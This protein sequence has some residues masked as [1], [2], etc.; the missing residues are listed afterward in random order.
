[1]MK[2]FATVFGLILI[3]WG[4]D[5]SG[6]RESKL[7]GTYKLDWGGLTEDDDTGIAKAFL[8]LVDVQLVFEAQG[9]GRVLV[10]TDMLSNMVRGLAEAFGD[11]EDKEET[12]E[13]LNELEVGT[14]MRWEVVNNELRVFGKGDNDMEV[15]GTI[16]DFNGYDIINLETTDD[17]G[18][19]QRI[20]LIKE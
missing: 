9:K 4:C 5:A 8:G 2:K 19:K 18:K 7:R 20:R 15:V 3:L 14:P 1:M 13:S 10:G 12:E 16:V 11:D 6:F 17:D